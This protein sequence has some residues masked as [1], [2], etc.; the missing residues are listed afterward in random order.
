MK[1]HPITVL[2]LALAAA[3]FAAPRHASA[4]HLPAIINVCLDASGS[5]SQADFKTANNA[6]ARFANMLYSRSQRN[7]GKRCDWL[8]VNWFGGNEDFEGTHWINCS[9][10]D[11]MHTLQSH[12]RTRGHPAFGNTAI[13]TAIAM[14]TVEIVER[15]RSLPGAYLP[16][17]I[18]VTD[19]Q[20]TQSP[21]EVRN[22]VNE[23][24][25]NCP[26]LM[27]VIGVGSSASIGEFRAIA[28]YVETIQDFD[29]L[30]GALLAALEVFNLYNE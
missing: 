26:V 25:P 29:Q 21:Y 11:D 30:S 2:L 24:Y 14:G 6:V 23:L 4:E 28:D 5:V 7:R 19:G 12:L 17:L 9:D 22:L 1:K 10:Q 8:T 27:M 20:D 15:D 13:Y 3:F 16:V 18:I